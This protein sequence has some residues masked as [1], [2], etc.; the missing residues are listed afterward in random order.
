MY[1]LVYFP[2]YRGPDALPSMPK[3]V[4]VQPQTHRWV[5]GGRELSRTQVPLALAWCVTVHKCQG[6]TVRK[7]VIDL[8]KSESTR[9]L[10]YV[11]LSRARTLT[12]IL[13]DPPDAKANDLQRFLSINKAKGREAR[14][15]VDERLEKLMARNAKA[16]TRASAP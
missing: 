9:G 13:P 15:G 8:G 14:R 1:V 11:A 4:P 16:L 7:I 5:S 2:E 10:T 6:W 3:V 12:D